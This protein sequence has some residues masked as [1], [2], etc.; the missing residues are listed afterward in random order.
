MYIHIY[1]IVLIYVSS[2]TFAVYLYMSVLRHLQC[3]Y[4]CNFSRLLCI[5][6]FMLGYRR[7]GRASKKS[8]YETS[9]VQQQHLEQMV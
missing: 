7:N 8:M 2:E 9:G 3:L 1:V 6:C 4:A 5:V